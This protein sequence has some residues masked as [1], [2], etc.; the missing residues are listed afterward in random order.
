MD[1][2]NRHGMLIEDLFDANFQDTLFIYDKDEIKTFTSGF[3][4]HEVK[5]LIDSVSAG[6]KLVPKMN[7]VHNIFELIKSLAPKDLSNVE[8]YIRDYVESSPAMLWNMLHKDDRTLYKNKDK[9]HDWLSTL[10]DDAM[11]SYIYKAA[12]GKRLHSDYVYESGN[13]YTKVDIL[14]G[15]ITVSSSNLD[16]LD[17]F[18][19]RIMKNNNCD[20]E[21]RIKKHGKITIHSY[22]FNMNKQDIN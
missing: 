21:H 6:Y 10:S 15:Y 8:E 19:D 20:F 2:I 5:R 9:F 12:D 17:N 13:P 14:D 1:I 22:V 3:K 4:S 16:A 7:Q 11:D 18:K